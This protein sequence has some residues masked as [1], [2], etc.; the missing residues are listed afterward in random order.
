MSEK[1][2]NFGGISEKNRSRLTEKIKI[3]LYNIR[4]LVYN[5]RR[6]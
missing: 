2:Q 4:R 5:T 1:M 6:D 3:P